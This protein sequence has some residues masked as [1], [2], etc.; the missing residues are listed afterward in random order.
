MDKWVACLSDMM[1]YNLCDLRTPV[2]LN[3]TACN[4]I[5][6]MLQPTQNGVNKDSKAFALFSKLMAWNMLHGVM[7]KRSDASLVFTKALIQAWPEFNN[8]ENV[9]LPLH[10]V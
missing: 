9:L 8:M 5:K 1:K 4:M 6:Y 2:S 7:F 10:W 3:V